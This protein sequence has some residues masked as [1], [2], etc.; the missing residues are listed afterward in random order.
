MRILLKILIFFSRFHYYLSCRF[1]NSI[2]TLS[3]KGIDCIKS[4]T[5]TKSA[6]KQNEWARNH[7]F[8]I[9]LK[10]FKYYLFGMEKRIAYNL[11]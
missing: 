9:F 1:R 4:F 5:H 7:G 6:T 11:K 10:S 3:Q 2:V 8:C